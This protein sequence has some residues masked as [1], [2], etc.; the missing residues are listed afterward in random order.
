LDDIEIRRK[1]HVRNWQDAWT[2]DFPW[3]VKIP[4]TCPTTGEELFKASCAICKEENMTRGI[5]AKPTNV[6]K[7]STWDD[8]EHAEE[9]KTVSVMTT[10]EIL[11]TSLTL[12]I[13][14]VKELDN[15]PLIFYVTG[16]NDPEEEG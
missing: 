14:L 10:L 8:H 2:K 7:K 5:G 15:T 4:Y 6:L 16:E 1:T 11:L 13:N 9:H 3:L 12:L